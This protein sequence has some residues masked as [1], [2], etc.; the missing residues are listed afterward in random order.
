MKLLFTFLT[1]LPISSYAAN[2][3]TIAVTEFRQE[4]DWIFS[5]C[6]G[7]WWHTQNQLKTVLEQEL[8]K[9]GFRVVERQHIRKMHENEHKMENLDPKTKAKS[10]QFIAAKYSITGGITELGICEEEQGTGI[11]LGGVVSLLGGPSTD[12]NVNVSGAV[13]KVKLV[14]KLLS[15][16]TGEVLKVFEAESESNDKGLGVQVAIVG[17]GGKHARKS[18]PPIERATNDA[19]KK[20][21][22]QIQEYLN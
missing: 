9:A 16:E 5:G 4:V 2:K 19:L 8:S 22:T 10:K 6:K 1:L 7:Y 13:S 3:K 21:A 18:T 14:A 15:V 12:L 17:I 20:I 11:N